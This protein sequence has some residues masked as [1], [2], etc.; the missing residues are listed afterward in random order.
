M[1]VGVGVVDNHAL[2]GGVGVPRDADMV[3]QANLAMNVALRDTGIELAGQG[4]VQEQRT[5]LGAQ[6]R[7]HH[8]DQGLEL[9]VEALVG[10]EPVRHREQQLGTLALG[11]PADAAGDGRCLALGHRFRRLRFRCLR[12]LRRLRLAAL[13][14]AARGAGGSGVRPVSH[15]SPPVRRASPRSWIPDGS[16]RPGSRAPSTGPGL[17]YRCAAAPSDRASTRRW[18]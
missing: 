13:G 11:H 15:G 17:R 6:H 1:F 2:A 12:C 4:I 9:L 16:P 14:R 10:G 5:A 7:G 3:E 8:L 18:P